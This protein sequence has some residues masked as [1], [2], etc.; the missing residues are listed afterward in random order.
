MVNV[1]SGRVGHQ[2]AG[3]W[4]GILRQAALRNFNAS[5]SEWGAARSI[6]VVL[7]VMTALG[8]GLEPG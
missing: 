1:Y 7:M 3:V 4:T 2:V 8:N 5:S 6:F